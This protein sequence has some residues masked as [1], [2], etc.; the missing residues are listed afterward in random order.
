IGLALGLVGFMQSQVFGLGFIDARKTGFAVFEINLVGDVL[1]QYVQQ[2][3]FVSQLFFRLLAPGNVAVVGDQGSNRRIVQAVV[4][5]GFD[6]PPGTVFM[7]VTELG[8]NVQ[9][10]LLEAL[11]E[12][13]FDLILIVGV[14]LLGC[15]T[16]DQFLGRVTQ[17]SLGGG[18]GV[19]N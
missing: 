17:N 2:V 10:R 16:S 3:S 18:A 11:G 9:A 5:R 1:H 4:N 14:N 13:L 19:K 8:M 6:I 12:T 7:G 15:L